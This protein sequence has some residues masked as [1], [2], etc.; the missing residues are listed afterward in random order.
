MI[1]IEYKIKGESHTKKIMKD[2]ELTS[3]NK[4]LDTLSSK[5]CKDLLHYYSF[6]ATSNKIFSKL[7]N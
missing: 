5:G 1:I 3:A 4:L 6:E 2:T 7:S